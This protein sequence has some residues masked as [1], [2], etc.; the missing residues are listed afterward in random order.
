MGRSMSS[1]ERRGKRAARVS[2]WDRNIGARYSVP[3]ERTARVGEKFGR[4][5]AAF[6]T[7]FCASRNRQGSPRNFLIGT[8]CWWR[9]RR[10]G[11]NRQFHGEVCNSIEPRRAPV[12]RSMIR[13]C[14]PPS[15]SASARAR[16]SVPAAIASM[17]APRGISIA[18]PLNARAV[19]GLDPLRDNLP[20]IAP[21]RTAKP[22]M[23]IIPITTTRILSPR[24][25]LTTDDA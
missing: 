1:A 6:K 24:I 20:A 17:R 16:R 25:P 22:T 13:S 7:T 2:V 19:V 9:D 21:T 12:V 10:A 4:I 14:R 8:L 11:P 15:G 23:S 3:P 18:E 5:D